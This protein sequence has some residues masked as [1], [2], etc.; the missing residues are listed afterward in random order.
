MF[1]LKDDPGANGLG[2]G[3]AFMGGFSHGLGSAGRVG[4]LIFRRGLAMAILGETMG[5]AAI[6]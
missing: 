5:Q 1:S 4:L 6:A 3:L 2:F